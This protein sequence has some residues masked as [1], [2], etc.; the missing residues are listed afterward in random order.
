MYSAYKPMRNFVAKLNRIDSL[1]KIWSFFGN[2]ERGAPLPQQFARIGKHGLASL[3]EV[4]HPWEL[5]I[6][7]REIILHAQDDR[8]KDLYNT[9][10]LSV[11][12][13]HIRRIS[14]AQN[15]NN[16]E[17]TLYQELQRL[18]QQQSLWRTNTNLM[19]ARHFKIY[20]TPNLASFIERG[21]SLS[22][23][24]LYTLGISISGHFLTKHV[25]NTKQDYT[26]FGISDEQRDSFID[27]VVFGFDAL[28]HRTAKTQ[29]YNENW[30]YTINPLISTPLIAF[31]QATPNL[32]ICPIPF[33]LM[34]R[35]SEGLFFDF[36]S[37]KG[38]EQAYGDAFEQYV[39]DVS[40]TLNTNHKVCRTIEIIKPNPYKIGKNEKHGVDLLIHDATG[41]ALVECK[42]KRLNLRARYQLDDDALYSEIDILAKYIVQNYKNLEDIVN[43]HTEWLPSDRSLFPI[44]VTLINWNLFAPNVHERMEE[45][46]L[47]LLDKA[48]ISRDVLDLYPYTVMSVEEYEI[49]FQLISQVGVK[50]F[51]SK[52]ANEYQ[53]GWMVMPFIHTNFPKEL[54]ACRNDYLNYVL[55]DLQ[56]E[57]ASGI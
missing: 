38:H 22:I 1:V 53:K 50:E 13:N 18:Y 47:K 56:E 28:K 41:A 30:S 9:D 26:A 25:F 24:Q 14:E 20:S 7:T 10:H 43:G 21:T 27:K 32:V 4:A 35:F 37:I 29:E 54:K 8:I 52:R 33:Y 36:T 48:G 57:L 3:K 17:K 34:Y 39:H 44:V 16:L 19:L 23:K 11:A 46:V 6:L 51:F 31:N 12:I 42:A 45:S 15:A 40:K 2:L 5:D 55:N 49:A